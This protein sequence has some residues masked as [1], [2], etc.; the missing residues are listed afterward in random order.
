MSKVGF[1][2]VGTMGCPMASNIVSKG[3]ELNF[4]D[5]FV[6]AENKS[7]L[8]KSLNFSFGSKNLLITLHP[9]TLEKNKTTKNQVGE[10]LEALDEIKDTKFIFTLPNADTNNLQISKMIIKFHQQHSVFLHQL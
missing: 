1:I 3:N 5:P 10:L 2:G 6:Q 9:E 7:K 8:E 4:Y